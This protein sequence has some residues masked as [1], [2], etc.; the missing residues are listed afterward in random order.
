MTK[1]EFIEKYRFTDLGT[2]AYAFS[3]RASAYVAKETTSVG[4]G[5]IVRREIEAMRDKILRK[6][7]E[8]LMDLGKLEA[9][10]ELKEK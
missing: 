8:M 1:Q 10:S 2:Y 6:C 9:D 5:F 4:W 7:D 3:L